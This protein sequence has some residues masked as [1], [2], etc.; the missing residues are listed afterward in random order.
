TPESVTL[1]LHANRAWEGFRA[2]QFIR[3][4][5]EIDG[6][7]RERC[8][9]PASAAGLARELELTVKRHPEGL[10]SNFLLEHA[11][12]GKVLRLSQAQGEFHLPDR[13][14]GRILLI[15]G[16][17]GITPVM[18]MLRTLCAEGHRGPIT[19]LHYAPDPERAIYREAL[20]HLA[21]AHPNLR[22]ARSY[23][24]APGIGEADG[25]FS[26]SQ[27][28]AV[29]P[30]FGE[31]ETFV[32][33]PPALLGAVAETW[34]AAGLDSRLHTESFV[35]PRIAPPN[36][37]AEGTV[38][39]AASGVSA[40]NTGAA[41]LEQAEEA[42]LCPE[43]GCRMGICHTCSRRKTAG[44]VRNLST[45]EVSVSEDEEIQICVSAP[46]GDVVVDL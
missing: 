33:G 1:A 13:A 4:G 28:E 29:E 14:P 21:A 27:L 34:S 37:V 40:K 32:C 46:I 12:P 2:G 41:L 17:S 10:V 22:L 19:F 39:F 26:L 7:W 43:F 20:E 15:S 11:R 45:G 18:S 16:G 38:S 44:R 42:G 31:A 23:T 8:Y 35:A 9:S 3:L 24:R 30:R 25:R 36:G 6:S 5:A